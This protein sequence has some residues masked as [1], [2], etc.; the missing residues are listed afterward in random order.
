[1]NVVETDVEPFDYVASLALLGRVTELGESDGAEIYQV[2]DEHL[3]VLACACG[4][5]HYG[6]DVLVQLI[7]PPA[8]ICFHQV[9]NP[10]AEWEGFHYGPE[11]T[12]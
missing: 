3:L 5:E 11:E 1:M 2:N 8:W 12:P 6:K 9:R 10:F 4:R 7:V